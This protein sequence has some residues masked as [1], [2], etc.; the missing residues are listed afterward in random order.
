V[1]LIIEHVLI[2]AGHIVDTADTA[3]GARELL[4]SGSYDI[5]L[6]DVRLPNGTG[7]EVA[8]AASDKGIKAIIITDTPFRSLPRSESVMTFC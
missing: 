2:D 7:M 6:T 4:E 1:R 8:D 5:L 3:R